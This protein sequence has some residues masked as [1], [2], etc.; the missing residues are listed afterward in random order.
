MD[1]EQILFHRDRG[2]ETP[3]KEKKNEDVDHGLKRLKPN[4]KKANRQ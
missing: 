2:E 3:L 4:Q 1:R